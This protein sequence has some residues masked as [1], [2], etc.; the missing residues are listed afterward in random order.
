MQEDGKAQKLEQSK[1]KSVRWGQKQNK[2]D[3]LKMNVTE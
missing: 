1:F 2:K 3:Y